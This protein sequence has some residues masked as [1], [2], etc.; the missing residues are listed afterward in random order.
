MSTKSVCGAHGMHARL[1]GASLYGSATYLK[2]NSG[3]NKCTFASICVCVCIMDGWRI[4]CVHRVS[5]NICISFI[6]LPS[7]PR[8]YM[9]FANYNQNNSFYVHINEQ[10]ELC[11]EFNIAKDTVLRI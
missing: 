9:R 5:F 6:Y 7:V 1:N 3:M 11:L 8:L 2:H 10:I 4:L